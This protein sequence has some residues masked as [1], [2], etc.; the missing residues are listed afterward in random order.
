MAI[1]FLSNIKLNG[2][3]IKELVVDHK[4]GS[5]PTSAYHGQLIFRTDQNKIYINQST[6]YGSPSWSSIAGD[7]T[8]I[9]AG[10]GLTTPAGGTGDVT[11]NACLL[12]T[13]PSPRDGLLSRMPSSA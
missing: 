1:P 4:S 3:Q 10:T 5:Q 2:N 13:S 11:I 9:T 12:Y 6:T 8:S 7:I